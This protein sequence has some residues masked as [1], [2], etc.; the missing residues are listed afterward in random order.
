MPS[1]QAARLYYIAA[2]F[3]VSS[4]LQARRSFGTLNV[5]NDSIERM[6]RYISLVNAGM[7]KQP[8]LNRIRVR[9]SRPALSS[10]GEE[11]AIT[12]GTCSSAFQSRL[13]RIATADQIARDHVAPNQD[14]AI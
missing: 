14:R 7:V 13:A 3:T 10:H 5:S 11:P 4:R 8:A 1:S 2:M 6:E 12:P 9:A